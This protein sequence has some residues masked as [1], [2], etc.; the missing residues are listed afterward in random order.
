VHQS[1]RLPIAA[2]LLGWGIVILHVENESYTVG[3]IMLMPERNSMIILAKQFLDPV[4]VVDAEIAR[5]RVE[6]KVPLL[7]YMRGEL[8][9]YFK[10]LETTFNDAA[11]D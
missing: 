1:T 9:G 5:R 11:T 4:N 10:L 8:G 6:W 3:N 7:T 2:S